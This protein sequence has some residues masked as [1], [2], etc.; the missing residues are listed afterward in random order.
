M[1]WMLLPLDANAARH[2]PTDA[3]SPG[4]ALAHWFRVACTTIMNVFRGARD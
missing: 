2:L 4:G 3:D 1:F